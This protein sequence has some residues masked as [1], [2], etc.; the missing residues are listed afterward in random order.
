MSEKNCAESPAALATVRI[1]AAKAAAATGHA[2]KLG[3][4]PRTRNLVASSQLAHRIVTVAS[5]GVLVLHVVQGN[6][7]YPELRSDLQKYQDVGS[8]Y[9][10]VGDWYVVYRNYY[11]D[12]YFGK[13]EKCVKFSTYGDYQNFSKAAIATFGTNGVGSGR[14]S[15]SSTKCY[16]AKNVLIFTPRNG[17]GCT[18]WLHSSAVGQEHRGCEF[19]YDENCGS[20]PKYQIYDQS[21]QKQSL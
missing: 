7:F 6:L 12:P 2:G 13:A 10:D 9:P 16:W 20:S 17:Y 4:Q 18:Y 3:D 8:C 19:I 1:H 14:I 15:L 5:L 21:C 11:E